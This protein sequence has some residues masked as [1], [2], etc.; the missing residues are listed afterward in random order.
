[1]KGEAV[2]KKDNKKEERREQISKRIEAGG[3]GRYDYR[4]KRIEQAKLEIKLGKERRAQDEQ[5]AREAAQAKKDAHRKL[6]E[7]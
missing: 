3:Q 6:E 7:G 2:G 5:T 1:M 4:Q